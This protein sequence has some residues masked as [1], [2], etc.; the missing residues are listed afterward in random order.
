MPSKSNF[1]AS[2]VAP[3][4]WY[5]YVFCGGTFLLILLLKSPHTHTHTHTHT[6]PPLANHHCYFTIQPALPR[7]FKPQFHIEFSLSRFIIASFGPCHFS[8]PFR[9]P[10]IHPITAL[11]TFTFLPPFLPLRTLV[12]FCLDNAYIK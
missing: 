4:A 9:T 12:H 7:S 2:K 10:F 11:I 6:H 3:C 8:F 1:G 5:L